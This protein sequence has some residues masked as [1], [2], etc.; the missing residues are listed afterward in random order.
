MGAPRLIEGHDSA[1]GLRFGIVLSRFNELITDGLLK[2]AL[3]AL[4]R[5]GA[6]ASQICIARVPGAFEIPLVAKKMAVSMAYDAVICLGAV[7]RGDTPHFEY[8]SGEVSRGL[9][10]V[11]L[12]TGIPVIFGVLTTDTVA[13][14]EQ[15]SGYPTGL[16]G[17]FRVDENH[18]GAQA[19]VAG[20]EMANLMRAIDK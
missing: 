7:I 3:M 11:S 4:E 10:A 14:A 1:R 19:A 15:R 17:E 8:I 12:E 13:Q 2:G 20:V 16:K 5:Q 9:A 6:E 18:R